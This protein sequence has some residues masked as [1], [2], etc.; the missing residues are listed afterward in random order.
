MDGLPPFTVDRYES[1]A[2][3]TLAE[4]D[5]LVTEVRRLRSIL[6]E[7]KESQRVSSIDEGI[8]VS[9]DAFAKIAP[10]LW[11]FPAYYK[12]RKV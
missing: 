11:A 4:R 6:K 10:A 12:Q 2:H 1:F 8:V 7:L 3:C 9:P 5:W